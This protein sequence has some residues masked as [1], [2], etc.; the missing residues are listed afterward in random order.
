M[1]ANALVGIALSLV[2]L[3]CTYLSRNSVIIN[4]H[5]NEFIIGHFIKFDSLHDI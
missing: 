5:L 4:I 3:K 1:C 2:Y